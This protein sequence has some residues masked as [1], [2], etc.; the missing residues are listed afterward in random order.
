[1]LTAKKLLERIGEAI[2]LNCKSLELLGVPL[3]PDTMQIAVDTALALARVNYPNLLPEEGEIFTRVCGEKC[4]CPIVEYDD[5][6]SA[7]LQSDNGY[8]DS[9]FIDLQNNTLQ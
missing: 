7:I 5:I 8:V 4:N 9:T 3:R 6:F 2:T 1:M